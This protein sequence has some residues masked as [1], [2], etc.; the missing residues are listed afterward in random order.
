MRII[1]FSQGDSITIPKNI[2]K[3]NKIDD[4]EILSVIEIANKGALKN[5]KL[6]F[7]KGFGIMQ[8]SKLGLIFLWKKILIK[9]GFQV[10]YCGWFGGFSFWAEKDDSRNIFQKV[11]RIVQF[12]GS[13]FRI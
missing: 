7:L 6:L 8:A 5:K 10:L 1:I 3:L 4:I 12:I 9:Q 2:I 13:G 11:F